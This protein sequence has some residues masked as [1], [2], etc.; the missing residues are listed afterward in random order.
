MEGLAI[1]KSFFVGSSNGDIRTA[2]D[3]GKMLGDGAYGQVFLATHK[4]SRQVRAVKKIPKSRIKHPDRL[5]TEINVMK[6][7]DHPYIVK[8]YEV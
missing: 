6:I 7:A 8:L 2:Y 1:K 3:M 4:D 5:E